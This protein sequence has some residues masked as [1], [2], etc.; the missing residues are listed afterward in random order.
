MTAPKFAHS[1][2]RLALIAVVAASFAQAVYADVAITGPPKN[3][4]ELR[5]LEA[6]IEQVAAKVLASTVAIRIGAASGSGVIVS[7]DGYI[8]TAGHVAGKAGQKAKI[9][10]AD[11]K[12]VGAVTL[13]VY[14]STDAGMMKITDKNPDK[15]SDGGKWPFV[16][17]GKRDDIKLGMWCIAFGHPLG[18]KKDRPPVLRVGRVLRIQERTLQTDCPLIGGDSGGPLVDLNGK[19]I[20]IN[21]RI[22]GNITMNYHVP[23]DVFSNNWDRLA[24]GDVWKDE[25]PTRDDDEVKKAFRPAVANAAKCV[26]RIKCDGKEAVLGTIVGPDG[27]IITKASE[28]KGRIVCRLGDGRDLEARIVGVDSRF[29]LAMLKVEAMDLPKIHWTIKD[30]TVGQLVAAAGMDDD[31][32][33]IGAVSTPRRAIP[34]LRAAIGVMTKEGKQGPKIAGVMPKSPAHKAGVK[35]GDEITHVNGKPVKTRKEF[36]DALGKFRAGTKVKLTLR[37]DGTTVELTITLGRLV[38]PA[39]K[40]RDMLNR[41][42][43]GISRRHDDFPIVLQHD[44]VLRPTDCGS[45]LVDL[46]GKVIGVNIARGGR[47]ETYCVP[48]STLV[49]LMYPLMSGQARPKPAGSPVAKPAVTKTKKPAEPKKPEPKKPEPKKVEPKKVEPKKAEPKKV[50]PKKP[51]PKKAEPK[52]PEPKKAEPKKPEPK[53]AEPKKPEPK[54][55][56]PKKP[57]PKKAEP[58]KVEPKKAEPKKAEPKKAEPKKAEPKKAEPK[59]AEPKK[60][61]PKKAEPKKAEPKKAEPKKA[62]PKKAEPKKAEPKKAEPK[63]AEPKKVE[64]PAVL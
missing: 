9:I 32:L 50:E 7:E 42:G 35:Q 48:A 39:T 12:T 45:P 8:L 13:G 36:S 41:T 18:K 44:T 51:E 23:I 55:A 4:D 53:K 6:K 22:G 16:E 29:D 52:K 34:P 49:T 59:K 17:Q 47:A 1:L 15:K 56:E 11:G 57:E 38:T 3:I 63:K 24:K 37:R 30:Q 61:E 46:D 28:L 62:E 14:S 5:K 27:W 54:N 10:L 43:V 58:K 25:V 64:K 60:A 19:V 20:G 31:P 2:A 33:A 21:S 26:V 40:K